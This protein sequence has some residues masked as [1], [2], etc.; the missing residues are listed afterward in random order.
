MILAHRITVHVTV[1]PTDPADTM[2]V[3]S[4]TYYVYANGENRGRYV[5]GDLESG[6][7]ID[8]VDVDHQERRPTWKK[9]KPHHHRGVPVE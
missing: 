6:R 3:I 8:R 5:R 9:Q 7:G 2:P 1:I 4:T